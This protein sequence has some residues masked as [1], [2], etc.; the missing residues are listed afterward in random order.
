LRVSG[1]CF[2]KT[3]ILKPFISIGLVSIFSEKQIYK[4][5]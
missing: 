1:T 5:R 2:A 4:L 3:T